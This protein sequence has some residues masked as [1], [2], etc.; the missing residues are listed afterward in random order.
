MTE[1]EMQQLKAGEA[2]ES[3]MALDKWK[4]LLGSPEWKEVVEYL[5]DRYITISDTDCQTIR[6]LQARNARLNEIKRL[7]R[8]IKH[9]FNSH[10]ARLREFMDE[11]MIEEQDIPTPY[12]PY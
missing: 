3:Q 2:K 9:D 8:F 11:Q 5:E 6:D 12:V 7:F 4:R 1:F 10:S